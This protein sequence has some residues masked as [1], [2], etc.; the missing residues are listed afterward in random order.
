[1]DENKKDH[2]EGCRCFLCQ[3][4]HCAWCGGY[5]GRHPLVKLIFILVVLAVVFWLGVQ[6]GEVKS[7]YAGYGWGGYGPGGYRMMGSYGPGNAYYG[8]GPGMMGWY[9]PNATSTQK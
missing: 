8:Y 1:M 7:L 3:G 6:I 5:H 4:G 2:P 9:W